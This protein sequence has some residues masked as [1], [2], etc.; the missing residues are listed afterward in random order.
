MLSGLCL[1][2]VSVII[3]V[4]N[5]K[6]AGAYGELAKRKL[7][8]QA[9]SSGFIDIDC[10]ASESYK[11]EQTGLFYESDT[12]YTDTGETHKIDPDFSSS[13]FHRQQQQQR[14]NLRSFPKGTRNC[15]T[16]KPN[17]G[18]NKNYLIRAVF[19]Y[20]NYDN[21]NQTPEFELYLGVNKW[22][23]V[24]SAIS[25]R[26]II[27]I[28]SEAYIDVC[29]NYTG[30]GVPYISAL[31]LRPLDN[32]LYRIPNGALQNIYSYDLGGKN[33]IR[34]G[35]TAAAS[36]SASV[37]L[38]LVIK[39]DPDPDSTCYIYFHFAEIE[40]LDN[41]S[42]R[43]LKIEVHGVRN[44]SSKPLTLE[45]LMPMTKTSI[46]LPMSADQEVSFKIYAAEGSNLPLILN[47]VEVFLYIELPDSLT[48]FNDGNFL[49]CCNL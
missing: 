2:L 4:R 34:N 42:N 38:S 31:E 44:L 49:L 27:H 33:D 6:L 5:S 26:E 41:G 11:D 14:Y 24:S 19:E 46:G 30:M 32:S 25:M 15:Y 9:D 36:K 45:Y 35:Q 10:G 40:I 7:Q 16:L 17:Q 20:G 43:E 48:N 1:V 18:G 21:K 47:A 8:F 23:T 22:T 39:R 37:P 3:T 28:P 29:L 13:T 12:N